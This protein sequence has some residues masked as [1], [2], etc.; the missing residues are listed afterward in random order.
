MSD[1]EQKV[2]DLERHNETLRRLVLALAEKL[3]IVAEHLGKLS[4]RPECRNR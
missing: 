2:R 1:I 4:E 3:L